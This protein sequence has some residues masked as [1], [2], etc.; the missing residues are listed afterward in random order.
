MTLLPG[1]PLEPRHPT[2]Q[3]RRLSWKYP[4]I[5]ANAI[6]LL[7]NYVSLIDVYQFSMNLNMLTYAAPEAVHEDCV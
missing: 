6:N 2:L 7:E 1:V 5:N 3:G 4:S